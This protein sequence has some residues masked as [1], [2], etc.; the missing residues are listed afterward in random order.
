M[1]WPKAEKFRDLIH[2]KLLESDLDP[3]GIIVHSID[4]YLSSDGDTELVLGA[5]KVIKVNNRP[6]WQ[7][8]MESW[9]ERFGKVRM[10][11]DR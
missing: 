2:N 1:K 10:T 8:Q 7:K 3:N 6:L 11:D 5:L 9:S 4:N